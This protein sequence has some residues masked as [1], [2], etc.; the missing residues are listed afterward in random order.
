MHPAVPAYNSNRDIALFAILV[1]SREAR[2]NTALYTLT[3]RIP[4]CLVSHVRNLLLR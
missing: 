3:M 4:S 2:I 1:K